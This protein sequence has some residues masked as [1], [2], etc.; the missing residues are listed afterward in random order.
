VRARPTKRSKRRTVE[1]D[2]AS[3]FGWM[4]V[5]RGEDAPEH[6]NERQPCAT[7]EARSYSSLCDIPSPRRGKVHDRARSRSSSRANRIGRDPPAA[8]G[9]CSNAHASL[10]PAVRPARRELDSHSAA[11][12]AHVPAPLGREPPSLWPAD[13]HAPGR[14]HR[15]ATARSTLHRSGPVAPSHKRW[16]I[17]RQ[18]QMAADSTP[19]CALA[20]LARAQAREHSSGQRHRRRGVTSKSDSADGAGAERRRD[21]DHRSGRPTPMPY[22]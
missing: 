20:D 22:C 5:T 19:I 14:Q 9:E 2:R 11:S 4:D 7:W 16:R 10:A 17:S 3:S 21:G 1:A 8:A 6:F 18:R 15:R 12:C 13:P